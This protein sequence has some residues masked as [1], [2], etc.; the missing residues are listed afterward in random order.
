MR[1][2]Y[3]HRVDDKASNIDLAQLSLANLLHLTYHF[4]INNN[5]EELCAL[6]NRG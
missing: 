4:S 3:Y 5:Y 6:A 2:L 1:A